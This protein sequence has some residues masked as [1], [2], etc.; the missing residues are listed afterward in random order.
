MVAWR[1]RCSRDILRPEERHEIP[2][3]GVRDAILPTLA[4]YQRTITKGR[5]ELNNPF[6]IYLVDWYLHR[7][8]DELDGR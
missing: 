8:Y 4:G 5:D 6:R 1:A 2:E 7:V 3:A